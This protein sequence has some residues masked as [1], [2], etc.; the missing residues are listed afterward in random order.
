M[1]SPVADLISTRK[2]LFVFASGYRSPGLPEKY[3]RYPALQKP[4]HIETLAQ[5]IE[6]TLKT[7][8]G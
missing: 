2:R 3:R 7:G 4:F 6:R 8:F 1:I 5:T